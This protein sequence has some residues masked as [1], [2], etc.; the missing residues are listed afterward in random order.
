MQ[1]NL[2]GKSKRGLELFWFLAVLLVGIFSIYSFITPVQKG[3]IYEEF[4][5]NAVVVINDVVHENVTANGYRLRFLNKGD[6]LS[7]YA[8]VPKGA[9]GDSTFVYR[10]WHSSIDVY[11]DEELIYT[12]GVDKLEQGK[13]VGNGY[14]IVNLPKSDSE[15]PELKVVI[16]VNE[17]RAFENIEFFKLYKG[18]DAIAFV[19]EVIDIF[20]LISDAVV[21]YGVIGMIAY[22]LFSL[23][24]PIQSKYL[25]YSF[26]AVL[27]LGVRG[28][29][30]FGI[31]QL[32]TGE[33]EN[34]NFLLFISLYFTGFFSVLAIENIDDNTKKNW[35]IKLMKLAY[36]VSIAVSIVLHVLDIAHISQPLPFFQMYA[37]L[38]SIYVII[39]FGRQYKRRR[40]YEKV[41]CLGYM[42]ASVSV[43]MQIVSF[44]FL[45]F[46]DV[47]LLDKIFVTIAMVILVFT[48]LISH[49]YRLYD[50]LYYEQEVKFLEAIAFKDEL[51]G[52]DNRYSGT[53]FL[54]KLVSAGRPY[55]TVLFD[56]NNLKKVNDGYGHEKGDDLLR[57]FSNILKL[58]FPDK[59]CMKMRQG[60]DEFLVVMDTDDEA[61]ALSYIEEMERQIAKANKG[62][63]QAEMISTAYGMAYSEEVDGT[64]YHE[65]L[66]L[67]DMRMYE[68]KKMMKGLV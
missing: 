58:S 63:T 25:F 2:W 42:A 55:F 45:R 14:H 35:H 11:L 19:R 29:S 33:Y 62:A 65:V 28:H 60:G 57:G 66:K 16:R 4:G 23:I 64:D 21:L 40:P 32:F 18:T 34:A 20:V 12:Y 61:E 9:P 43:I 30:D 36:I 68:N 49:F 24:K 50:A 59:N 22:F 8:K 13:M 38:L 52:L 56:L 41:L 27:C 1:G 53:A 54:L 44:E 47:K 5:E 15:E 39:V 37:F 67:A 3:E 48:P 46:T 6:V 51:T 10:T 31:R 7:V 17:D 26:A